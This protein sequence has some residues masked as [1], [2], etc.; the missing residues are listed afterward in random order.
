MCSNY[1]GIKLEP[2]FQRYD[3]IETLSSYAHVVHTAAKQVISR[4]ENC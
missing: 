2:A 3:K 4:R 1:P